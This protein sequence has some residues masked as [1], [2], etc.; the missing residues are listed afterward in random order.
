MIRYVLTVEPNVNSL[1]TNEFN[2]V[3]SSWKEKVLTY[4]KQKVEIKVETKPE[5]LTIGQ[6]INNMKPATLWSILL[7]IVE[8]LVSAFYIGQYFPQK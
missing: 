1:S 2:G 5:E 6:I 8:L 4:Q 3:I 7:A